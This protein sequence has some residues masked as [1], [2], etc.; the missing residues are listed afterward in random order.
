MEIL[1]TRLST[2]NVLIY[3]IHTVRGTG[4]IVLTIWRS[5]VRPNSILFNPL[6]RIRAIFARK[7]YTKIS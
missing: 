1:T 7:V 2:E 4:R 5:R 3:K 6:D